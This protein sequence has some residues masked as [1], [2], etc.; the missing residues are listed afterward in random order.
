M[1]VRP[2]RNV[3]TH[4]RAI[5]A[6]L[7]EHGS[8]EHAAGVQWFFKEDVRSYGWYTGDLRAYGRA[9]HTELLADPALMLDVADS[10]F[11]GRSLEEKVLAVVV[12]ARSLPAAHAPSATRAAASRARRS[13]RG[14]ELGEPEFARFVAWLDAVASWADHDAL[15]MF[16]LGPMMA[17]VPSRVKRVHPWARSA[18]RWHRRAAAVSLI[19]GIQQGLFEDEAARVTRTLAGD[20]DDMVQKGLG[21]LLRVWGS[22]RPKNV[23]PL[24]LEIRPKTSRLVLRTACERLPAR[25][26]ALVLAK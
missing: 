6:H 16:L 1:T 24:L 25:D 19:R 3:A 15:A 26:R 21:W 2:S 4:A 9:L 23:V 14:F 8:S 7:R 18:N 11:S 13:G 20:K 22:L 12:V 10:L 5:R 17:A